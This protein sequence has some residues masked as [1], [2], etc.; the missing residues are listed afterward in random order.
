MA[1]PYIKD[2]NLLN[3]KHLS[4][5]LEEHTKH[6]VEWPYVERTIGTAHTIIYYIGE[7]LVI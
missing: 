1:R 2:S 7:V 6:N 4:S 5:E 3:L